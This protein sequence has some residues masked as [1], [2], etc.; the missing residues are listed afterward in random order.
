MTPLPAI[1][2]PKPR[3]KKAAEIDDLT[4]RIGR[5]L[6]IDL[7]NLWLCDVNRLNAMMGKPER[8]DYLDYPND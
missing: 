5:N 8:Y 2:P 1:T 3:T 4:R 7:M 6:D